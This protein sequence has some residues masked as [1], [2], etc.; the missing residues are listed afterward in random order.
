LAKKVLFFI[1]V[2]IVLI[3]SLALAG[4]AMA[5]SAVQMVCYYS[6]LFNLAQN[7]SFISIIYEPS[8]GAV[9]FERTISAG[10]SD[11]YNAI[12][13][14][15]VPITAVEDIYVDGL[16]AAS[17]FAADPIWHMPFSD[18]VGG[19]IGDGRINDGPNELGAPLAA[20]CA[21]GD[22]EVWEIDENAQGI[23][24]FTVSANEIDIALEEAAS[25][26]LPT[27]VGSGLGN[28]LYASPDGELAV[29]G[30]DFRDESKTY[31]F[32]FPGNRCG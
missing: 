2:G 20:Y 18:C 31:R 27:L 6:G 21:D 24:G 30:P 4:G 29:M 19:R 17:Y 8:S 10:Q 14:V 32:D 9:Y 26:G 12:T 25:N 11:P 5:Q 1:T 23:L 22:I 15:L 28:S 7:S 13:P 3:L 16:F